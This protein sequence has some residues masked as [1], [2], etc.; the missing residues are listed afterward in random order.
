[1]VKTMARR[2]SLREQAGLGK[3]IG[4]ARR[5]PVIGSNETI[6]YN[7]ARRRIA[8]LSDRQRDKVSLF[9]RALG[10]AKN[11]EQARRESGLSQRGLTTYR[12]SFATSGRESASPWQ[13]EKG[14]WRF[15]PDRLSYTH[16]FL[17]MRDGGRWL[18][19]PFVGRELIAMQNWRAA[20]FGDAETVMAIPKGYQARGGSQSALDDWERANPAGVLGADGQTYWPETDYAAVQARL[21]RMSARQRKRI[22]DKVYYKTKG[23][24]H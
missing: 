20:A 9:E 8:A 14:R 7:E 15:E 18:D 21:K 13:K 1:M 12:K 5:Y 17:D 19:A 3:P 24:D 11:V 4:K 22:M 23:K 2:T 16:T 6:S 10:R